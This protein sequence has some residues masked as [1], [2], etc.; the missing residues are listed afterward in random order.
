MF[1]VLSDFTKLIRR[2]QNLPNPTNTTMIKCRSNHRMHVQVSKEI[3]RKGRTCALKSMLS[4]VGQKPEWMK[5][6]V[7]FGEGKYTEVPWCPTTRVPPK[8]P[9]C[10]PRNRNLILS[11][12]MLIMWRFAYLLCLLAECWRAEFGIVLDEA[13]PEIGEWNGACMPQWMGIGK[14]HVWREVVEL[15]KHDQCS[16]KNN[17]PEFQ[18]WWMPAYTSPNSP[19]QKLNRSHHHADFHVPSW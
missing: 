18:P 19:R 5:M 13:P 3:I 12:P 11:D 10:R 7:F 9:P 4:F 17:R 8:C 6:N 14:P 16:S 2:W 15:K 1:I